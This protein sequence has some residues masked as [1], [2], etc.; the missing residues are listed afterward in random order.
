MFCSGA[1]E[2]RGSAWNLVSPRHVHIESLWSARA[3]E[4]HAG[5]MKANV[6]MAEIQT[7]TGKALRFQ[8]KRY[9]VS[10]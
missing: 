7:C 3:A 8:I 5:N 4:V 6:V 10:G 1:D 2:Q 9:S